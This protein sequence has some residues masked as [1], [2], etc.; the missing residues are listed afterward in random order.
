MR[1]T[2]KHQGIEDLESD[3]RKI[4][5]RLYHEGSQIIR[6]IVRDGGMTARRIATWTAGE[7]GKRYPRAITWDRRSR[8]FFGFGGGVMKG[9]Y[10]PDSSLPQ[11]DMSFEGGSRNQKPHN[12]LANSLDLIRPKFHRDVDHMLDGLFWPGGEA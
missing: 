5:P 6:D 11:G 3:M 12:D 7:H 10:G 9:E 4:P 1:I 8:N 2:V